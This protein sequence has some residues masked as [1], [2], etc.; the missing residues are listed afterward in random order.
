MESTTVEVIRAKFEALKPVMDE[1]TRRLWAATEARAIGRGGITRVSQATGISHVTIRA[2][3]SQLGRPPEPDATTGR[4][5]RPGGGRKPLTHHDPGL[6]TALE[7]LVEPLTRG[8]PQSPLRW[9]CKSTAK[10]A[11]ELNA[12]GHAVS[13]RTINTLLARLGYSLQSNRKTREGGKHPDRNAQFEHI[14]AKAES[15]VKAGQPV[16]SV[17]TKKKELVGDFKNGGREWQPK[18]QPEE[19]R[20][21][22][23]IDPKLGKAIPYGVYDLAANL[24]WVSVG[25]DH[26]TA[27]FAVATLR[28][29]WRAVGQRDVPGC[30]AAADHGRRGR[31]QREPLPALEAEAPGVRRRDRPAGHGV[32]LPA[33][34]EQV[35]QDRAPAV[36]PHHAELAGPPAGGPGVRRQ[37]DREH[38]D[39]D[40][41]GDPGGVGREGVP[42]GPGGHAGGDGVHLNQ[43]G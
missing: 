18:G 23:F 26:D 10:L 14:N 20:V 32:P 19:V 38:D 37:P 21:H 4:V 16:V 42:A 8:D 3:L 2:G 13:P 41:P 24:G 36:L 35:E 17:D 12:R 22:D 9:T 33:G 28:R 29:W 39:G 27:E 25:V 11:T 30:Q 6:L 7:S 1:R 43:G 15:F 40:G 34:H 31:L 5:R